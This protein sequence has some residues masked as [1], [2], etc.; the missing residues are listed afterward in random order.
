MPFKSRSQMR[1]FFAMESRGELPKGKAEEWAHE[2]PSIKKLPEHVKKSAEE[3][4]GHKIKRVG[5]AGGA[6]ALAVGA[7]MQPATARLLGAQHFVHGTSEQ[8]AKSIL[9]KGLDPSYGGSGAAASG[10]RVMSNA[11]F[12]NNSK[13]KVHVGVGAAG[14]SAAKSYARMGEAEARIP[15]GV[16]GREGEVFL[17]GMNP[18][19]KYKGKVIGGALPYEHFIKNFEK[20]PDQ[21][22]GAMR[23]SKAIAA[24]HLGDNSV[25]S[26]MRLLY[27]NRA[28]KLTSYIRNHPGRFGTGAALAGGAIATPFV[29]NS[30]MRREKKSQLAHAHE[31]DTGMPK[32]QIRM[33]NKVEMEHTK[34]P[35]TAHQIAID[36]IE[37][38]PHYYTKLK[39]VEGEKKAYFA[40]AGR[41]L[42]RSLWSQ[43]G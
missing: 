33:G 39:K 5:A 29:V 19:S 31:R 43:R 23:T 25:M 7:T 38:D 21:P 30:F 13:N 14:A 9:Q 1:K 3:T 18:F 32:S 42:A 40:E 26:N 41:V 20:D 17:H 6:G 34:N 8:A 22:L 15:K 12:V 2:T 27:K 36:H 10:N 28:P 37:E 24:E 16:A 35:A 11:N 4:T